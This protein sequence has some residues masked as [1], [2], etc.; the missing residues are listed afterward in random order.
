[1]LPGNHF[2][3]IATPQFET[4]VTAFLEERGEC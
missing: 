3:A 1:M 2:T 4:A